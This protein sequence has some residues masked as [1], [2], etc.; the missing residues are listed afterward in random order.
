MQKG[1]RNTGAK[2]QAR[3]FMC[4]VFNLPHMVQLHCLFTRQLPGDAPHGS[5]PRP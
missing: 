4:G 5:S 2:K 3:T 1:S